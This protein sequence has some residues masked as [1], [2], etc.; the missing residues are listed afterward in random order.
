VE[1]LL[2][3]Y[4]WQEYGYRFGRWQRETDNE[5]VGFP[6]NHWVEAKILQLLDLRSGLPV[7]ELHQR[8]GVGEWLRF[9]PAGRV[10]V[11]GSPNSIAALIPVGGDPR[12][13]GLGSPRHAR[14]HH[15]WILARQLVHGQEKPAPGPYQEQ[16]PYGRST[17]LVD[18]PQKPTK[19]SGFTWRYFQ[20]DE[21]LD[22]A[23]SSAAHREDEKLWKALQATGLQ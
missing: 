23:A 12:R 1:L 18:C 6:L 14:S 2:S 22:Y 9:E 13:I 4:P 5:L 15:P 11:C 19:Q 7:A 17:W 8:S 20:V 10:W 16:Q 3:R 21:E